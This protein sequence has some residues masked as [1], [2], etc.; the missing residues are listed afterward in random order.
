[1][2]TK[3][4]PVTASIAV[5]GTCNE[6]TQQIYGLGFVPGVKESRTSPKPALRK[7]AK[8]SPE[9]GLVAANVSVIA[10]S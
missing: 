10:I 9:G 8:L 2:I 6:E 4:F 5:P 3:R 7:G 1:L